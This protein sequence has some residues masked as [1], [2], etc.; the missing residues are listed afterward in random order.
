VQGGRQRFEVQ[1]SI[2]TWQFFTVTA[3][4]R[5]YIYHRPLT[6]ALRALHYGRYGANGDE[7]ALGTLFVGDGT[8]V[9]G[10]SYNSFGDADCT[11]Q[12]SGFTGCAEFDRMLG[13]RMAVANVEL[14]L[15][16]VGN[17]RFGLVNFRFLPTELA[18]FA[19]AGVAWTGGESPTF[20]ASN[21]ASRSPITSAGITAR[22]NLFGAF[23][24]ETWYAHPFQRTTGNRFGLQLT[25]GW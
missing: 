22:F 19:D 23:I 25:P 10:Y 12:S 3:D 15:P 4:W 14:R 8:L 1:P 20:S 11:A 7:P 21:P 9:R 2:G 17:E 5:S 13:S 24:L 18:L 16:L 6:L